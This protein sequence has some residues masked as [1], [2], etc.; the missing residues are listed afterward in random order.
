MIL[1][2]QF[3]WEEALFQLA[4]FFSS[5]KYSITVHV[6]LPRIA[7][8]M[9][10]TR[11]LQLMAHL[12]GILR[13]NLIRLGFFATCYC[14]RLLVVGYQSALLVRMLLL[15]FLGSCIAS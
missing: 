4:Y 6:L 9:L 11:R 13:V 7:I 1:T 12:I 3:R 14:R 2:Q 8:T 15:V 5:G 10:V